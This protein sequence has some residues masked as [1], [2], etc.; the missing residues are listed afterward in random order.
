MIEIT[1][2]RLPSRTGVAPPHRSIGLP[3]LIPLIILLAAC[4]R[5]T[6]VPDEPW[7][8]PPG[9]TWT[10]DT[11]MVAEMKSSLDAELRPFL[12][13]SGRA[14]LP[15]MRYWF[16]YM[17]RGVDSSRYVEIRG[18]PFP[19]LPQGKSRSYMGPWMPEECIVHARYLPGGKRI[20]DLVLSGVSCPAR[21]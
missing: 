20:D 8:N 18:R 12:A 7:F 15:A 11:A 13:K 10:P 9:G 17:G 21:L 6:E 5:H 19:V 14:S 3:H 1:R 4:S 2:L 16:Q